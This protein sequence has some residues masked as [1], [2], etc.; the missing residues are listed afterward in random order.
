MGKIKRYYE[1]LR[2]QNNWDEAD[3]HYQEMKMQAGCKHTNK[4][5]QPQERENN[6]GESYTC[7]ECGKDFDIPEPYDERV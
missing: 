7:D 6:V 3:K 1:E 4:T 2:V 5:Y